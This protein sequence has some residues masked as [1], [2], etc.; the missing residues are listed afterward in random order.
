MFFIKEYCTKKD[1]KI[2]KRE[3]SGKRNIAKKKT[4]KNVMIAMIRNL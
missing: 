1:E 4:A 2:L 3:N